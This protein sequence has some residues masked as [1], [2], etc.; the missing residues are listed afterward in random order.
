MSDTNVL[1]K[2]LDDSGMRELFSP[3]RTTQAMR[4]GLERASTIIEIAPRV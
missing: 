2:W 4:D 1:E 3:H